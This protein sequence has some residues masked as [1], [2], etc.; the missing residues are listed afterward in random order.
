MRSSVDWLTIQI[1]TTEKETKWFVVSRLKSAHVPERID[2]CICWGCRCVVSG[3]HPCASPTYGFVRDFWLSAGRVHTEISTCWSLPTSPRRG[4][5]Q[6][7]EGSFSAVLKPNFASKYA[8]ESSR[9]DLHN[10][11]LCT[12]L[13][14]QIFVWKSLKMLPKICQF[15]LTLSKFR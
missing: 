9:R 10:A 1:K 5:R 12:V 11:L 15:L 13:N 3:L 4:M 6:T 2:T 8:L 14:A 7:L